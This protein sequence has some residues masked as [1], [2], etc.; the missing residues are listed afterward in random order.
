MLSTAHHPYQHRSESLVFALIAGAAATPA[1]IAT[2]EGVASNLAISTPA[3][4]TTPD[5]TAAV[6][7]VDPSVANPVPVTLEGRDRNSAS[8]RVFPST[9]LNALCGHWSTDSSNNSD[10]CTQPQNV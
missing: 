6:A 1:D 3:S 2:S 5:A 9:Q 7:P 4:V 8:N 10:I